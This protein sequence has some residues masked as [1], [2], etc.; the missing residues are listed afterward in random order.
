MMQTW[1]PERYASIAGFVPALGAPLIELLAPCAGE[2]ILDLGC[3]DGILGAGI[4]ARGCAVVGI[5]SS[6]AQVEAARARGL[7]ARVADGQAL[8]FNGEFDGVFT[9]AALHWMPRQD[10][11]LDGASRALRPGGR[12]VGEFGARGNV[13][14]I[15]DALGEAL[16]AIGVDATLCNPWTF[17]AGADF[18]ELLQMSG[19]EV[20][21]LEVFDRPTRFERELADWLTLMAQAFVNAVPQEAR[22]GVLV[23]VTERLRPVLFRD[24]AW[25]LDYVRLRFAAR[26]RG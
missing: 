15:V 22:S 1:D 26:K 23:S 16:S 17:P 19:F 9:N 5:D 18:R 12:F 20:Q 24:G 11:V 8:T 7:D 6:A 13:G 25:Q 14:R 2:R 3:G 10:L 4:A 21:T